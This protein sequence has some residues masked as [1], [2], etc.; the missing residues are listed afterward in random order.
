MLLILAETYAPILLHRK[1]AKIRKDTGDDRY[2]TAFEIEDRSLVHMLE[3]AFVR[4]F[5]MLTTQPIIQVLSRRFSFTRFLTIS[6]RAVL[7]LY[8]YG[9]L[10]LVLS[11]FPVLW[12]TQYHE[13]VGTAGLN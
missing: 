11:T 4:P 9:I 7:Q 12:E 13:R 8:N 1:A 3:V 6:D 5:R 10:Y 2:Y